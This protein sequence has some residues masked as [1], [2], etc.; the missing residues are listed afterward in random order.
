[1]VGGQRGPHGPFVAQIASTTS[2]EH[3]QIHLLQMVDGCVKE[4]ILCLP[5]VLAACVEVRNKTYYI[6]LLLKAFYMHVAL[7]R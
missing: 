4:R 3:V 5:I 1:M 7:C 6:V 2:D